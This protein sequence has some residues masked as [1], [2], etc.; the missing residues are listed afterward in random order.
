[1]LEGRFRYIM[2]MSRLRLEPDAA[3]SG[4]CH[5][6]GCDSRLAAG[7]TCASIFSRQIGA[8]IVLPNPIVPSYGTGNPLR[9]VGLKR[10]LESQ[11][12]MF[13]EACDGA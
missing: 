5:R 6:G 4:S 13:G 10:R 12:K 2:G 9:P 7:K 3:Q 11:D 1:M 8:S